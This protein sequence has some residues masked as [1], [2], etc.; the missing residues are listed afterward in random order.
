[1]EF[2]RH[3]SIFAALDVALD[4]VDGCF[5]IGGIY[6]NEVTARWIVFAIYNEFE[7]GLANVGCVIVVSRST[8]NSRTCLVALGI[9][10]ISVGTNVGIVNLSVVRI[11]SRCLDDVNPRLLGINAE[12]NRSGALNVR[13]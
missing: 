10:S 12:P 3:R 7:Y 13:R 4:D 8:G 1:M 9:G 5:A 2:D 11:V 6:L